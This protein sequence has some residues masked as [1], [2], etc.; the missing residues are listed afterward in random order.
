MLRKASVVI[1]HH[2]PNQRSRFIH[3]GSR[4]LLAK[5]NYDPH[6]HTKAGPKYFCNLRICLNSPTKTQIAFHKQITFRKKAA[7]NDLESEKSDDEPFPLADSE[8][9]NGLTYGGIQLDGRDQPG[10]PDPPDYE[11]SAEVQALCW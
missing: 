2:S 1:L 5:Q 11:Q 6:C 7:N 9:R 10:L 4:E 3:S 8:D